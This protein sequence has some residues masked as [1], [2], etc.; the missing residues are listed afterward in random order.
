MSYTWEGSSLKCYAQESCTLT[1][2]KSPEHQTKNK[3][4]SRGEYAAMGKDWMLSSK[5]C[6][7]WQI[8]KRSVCGGMRKITIAGSLV[9]CVDEQQKK[10]NNFEGHFKEVRKDFV[11]WIVPLMSN[12][13]K[14]TYVDFVWR[15]VFLTI[16]RQDWWHSCFTLLDQ[17][18]VSLA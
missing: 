14:M 10:H 2:I 7:C 16:I 4:F 9:F 5:A 8:G 3:C 15:C 1:S 12:F 17:N 11:F 13:S 6:I 18:I